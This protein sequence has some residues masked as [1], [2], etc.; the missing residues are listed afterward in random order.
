MLISAEPDIS[1]FAQCILLFSH[2][3]VPVHFWESYLT[4]DRVW[5]LARSCLPQADI[6]SELQR[7]GSLNSFSC[8]T[9]TCS[10]QP[11]MMHETVFNSAAPSGTNKAFL[12]LINLSRQTP[13]TC[14]QMLTRKG[15][16]NIFRIFIVWKLWTPNQM[17]KL[18][19][20]K[21][22]LISK[23]QKMA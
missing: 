15:F 1:F 11:Q 13:K 12:Q 2:N 8:H 17:I 4:D 7:S 14:K 19:D 20:N 21:T 18:R 23:T 22:D 16:N 5:S 10:L 6:K 3:L 9:P